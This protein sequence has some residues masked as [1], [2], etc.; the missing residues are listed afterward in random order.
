MTTNLPKSS[1]TIT[2]VPKGKTNVTWDEATFTWNQ[3][4]NSTWDA[5]GAIVASN[6]PKSSITKT[7]VNKSI[8]V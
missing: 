5:V 2:N 8:V 3:G 7:Q 1:T 4:S 6:L